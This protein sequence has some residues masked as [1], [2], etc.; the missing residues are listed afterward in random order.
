[1]SRHQIVIGRFEFGN[2]EVFSVVQT[3]NIEEFFSFVEKDN[4]DL[5]DWAESVYSTFSK[6][7]LFHD[8]KD[9]VWDAHLLSKEVCQSVDFVD[10]GEVT[11]ILP[12]KTHEKMA[13]FAG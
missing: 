1:M 6:G 8:E 11:P 10:F 12:L 5:E 9:A 3:N 7:R 2:S 4:P 13:A